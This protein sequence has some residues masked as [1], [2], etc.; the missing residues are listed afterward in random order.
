MKQ[1]SF[2]RTG[3]RLALR[4]CAALA[5]L[6]LTAQSNPKIVVLGMGPPQLEELR[7]AAPRGN[8]VGVKGAEEAQREVADADALIGGVTREMLRSARRLKWIQAG[9]AGVE[10]ILFP[11][12][13]S[14]DITLT[15]C[16]IIQGPEISDHAMALLLALTRRLNELIPLRETKEWPQR[17]YQTTHR[18]IE[19]NGRTALIVGLGGIGMQIAQRA[20]AFGM[21]VLAVD[22]ADMPMTRFVDE[23]A[24]V[25]RLRDF[26]P[27]ADVVFMAAPHT[28]ETERMLGPTEFNLMKQGAYFIAVSRGKTYDGNA[29]VKA[30]DEKRLAGAGLDVVDPEPLPKDN[31]LWRFSNVVITPHIAGQSD[32]FYVRQMS[33]F[34]E[35]ARRFTEGLPL[36]NVVDKRKGY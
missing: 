20:W 1:E 9:G 35:N 26:L 18:P 8:F 21:R 31:P 6:L 2:W 23:L 27:Q 36:I 19:L 17:E 30:L 4:A 22:P 11:E 10:T 32:K 12:L 7:A 3:G 16:K 14:S 15:N 29:L 13:V 5:P 33:V 24:P 34:K 28:P 25:D